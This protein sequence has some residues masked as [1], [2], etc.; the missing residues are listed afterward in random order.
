VLYNSALILPTR[1]QAALAISARPSAQANLTSSVKAPTERA[2]LTHRIRVFAAS[3]V[4]HAGDHHRVVLRRGDV[5]VLAPQL[6][7]V[8]LVD[9]EPL[10]QIG[11]AGH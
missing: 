9:D 4:G 8:L 6:V 5:E 10:Q 1:D 7:G 11:T 2:E 3:G